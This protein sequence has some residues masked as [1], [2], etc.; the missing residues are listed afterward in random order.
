MQRLDQMTTSLIHHLQSIIHKK[1]SLLNNKL[2]K[3]DALS[4]LATLKRGF[5]I[6]VDEKGNIIRTAASVKKGSPIKVKLSQDGL[7]CTVDDYIK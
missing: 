7:A 3:L 2:A 4:P 5:A 6:A 1:Q